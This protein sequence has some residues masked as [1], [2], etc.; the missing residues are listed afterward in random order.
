MV[1]EST[2]R[3]RQ[4][5]ITQDDRIHKVGTD[6]VLIG[7]WANVLP[8]DQN[9]LDIGTGTGLIA[10]MMAQRTHAMIDTIEP[11][12][13]A[14]E[15]A[16]K[17]ILGSPWPDR[18]RLHSGKLQEVRLNQTFDR[19]ISNPPF[20]FQRLIPPEENRKIQRHADALPFDVLAS[21]CARL[22]KKSGSVSLIL[23]VEES[24][25]AS[26]SFNNHNLYP[27]RITE[28]SSRTDH[29][30]IRFLQEYRFGLQE[31]ERTQLTLT[32][33]SGARSAEYSALTSDFYL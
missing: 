12:L 25:Q 13:L 22:L 30:P 15:I 33:E 9:I 4:F 26:K 6:G 27:A 20:F 8:S 1:K 11:D 17:N 16:T 10:L 3:F 29:A 23:P 5:E 19:I 7:A 14:L 21:H 31:C 2:F 24:H 28:V 32:N 18:I